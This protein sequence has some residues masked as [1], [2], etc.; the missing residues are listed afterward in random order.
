[1]EASSNGWKPAVYYTEVVT[2][3]RILFTEN[4]NFSFIENDWS[5]QELK[6]LIKKFNGKYMPV[7][8]LEVPSSE[9][10][11]LSEVVFHS[12]LSKEEKM[13]EMK[14]S[15]IKVDE[16]EIAIQ[17]LYLQLN[18]LKN[19][20]ERKR[21]KQEILFLYEQSSKTVKRKCFELIKSLEDIHYCQ[22]K[23]NLQDF[24]NN[25]ILYYQHQSVLPSETVSALS[26]IPKDNEL[27]NISSLISYLENLEINCNNTENLYKFFQE[28]K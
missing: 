13:E 18:N 23:R 24:A 25:L 8:N 7:I 17:E 19:D 4:F 2:L 6:D 26:G 15:E 27:N 3:L 10:E 11:V 12:V 21:K 28:I 9:T 16:E 14:E 22:E 20:K 5:H 1:M